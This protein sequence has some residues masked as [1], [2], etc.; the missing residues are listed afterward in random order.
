MHLE[1][2]QDLRISRSAWNAVFGTLFG[3]I[4]FMLETYR[5]MVYTANAVF[6]K[7]AGVFIYFFEDYKDFKSIDSTESMNEDLNYSFLSR[8]FSSLS[9]IQKEKILQILQIFQGGT[10]S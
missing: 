10:F 8:T 2:G 9:K 5:K 7:G 1:G 4:E 3:T 6:V